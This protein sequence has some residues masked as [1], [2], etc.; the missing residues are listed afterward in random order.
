MTAQ[1]QLDVVATAQNTTV[2]G[3]LAESILGGSTPA[4]CTAC[5]HIV[6]ELEPDAADATCTACGADQVQSIVVLAHA[7]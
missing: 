5:H 6:D 4:I 7:L 3:M 2:D 1:D